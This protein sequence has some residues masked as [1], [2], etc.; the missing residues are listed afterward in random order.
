MSF[1]KEKLFVFSFVSVYLSSIKVFTTSY[2]LKHGVSR[3]T[4][5]SGKKEIKRLEKKVHRF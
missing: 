3:P 4:I 2:L 5:L 1:E